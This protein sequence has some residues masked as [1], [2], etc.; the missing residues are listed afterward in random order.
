MKLSNKGTCCCLLPTHR[1]VRIKATMVK[2]G[3]KSWTWKSLFNIFEK[4]ILHKNV[5]VLQTVV[6]EL[7]IFYF[8]SRLYANLLLYLMFWWTNKGFHCHNLIWP[9]INCIKFEKCVTKN[10]KLTD[11]W[12]I[13]HPLKFHT[14]LTP[15]I[16]H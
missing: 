2:W 12:V 6:I 10:K 14:F 9:C 1:A 4:R 11:N 15:C 8:L 3:D 16:L 13:N 5:S 7:C